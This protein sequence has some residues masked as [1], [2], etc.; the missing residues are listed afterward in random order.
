MKLVT[1]FATGTLATGLAF[2][3]SVSID[4]GEKTYYVDTGTDGGQCRT[5]DLADGR[6]ETVCRD[7]NNEAALSSD[8]GC[9]DSAG[10]AYCAVG[11]RRVQPFEA[12]SELTCASGAAYFLLVGAEANCRLSGGSK[13]CTAR[14]GSQATADCVDGC[15]NTKGAGGCCLAG[16]T[17]CPPSAK[18]K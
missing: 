8:A 6:R 17:R 16:T 1:V 14:D 2:A 9:L 18:R 13:T 5:R 10:S 4:V 12:G 7:G 3:A 11:R 15:G